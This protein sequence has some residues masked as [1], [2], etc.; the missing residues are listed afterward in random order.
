MQFFNIFNPQLVESRDVKNMDMENQLY[1]L[2]LPP[3]PPPPLPS[4]SSS[5]SIV[6]GGFI[7]MMAEM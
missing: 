4:S 6:K 7:V 1:K 3:P 5:S 2:I